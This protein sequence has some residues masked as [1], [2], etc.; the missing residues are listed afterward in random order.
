M[1]LIAVPELGARIFRICRE[2]CFFPGTTRLPSS[3]RTPKYIDCS[4]QGL[5]RKVIGLDLLECLVM[6]DSAGD[7]DVLQL[8]C[9]GAIPDGL[10]VPLGVAIE[11]E[12]AKFKLRPSDPSILLPDVLQR[13]IR[14]GEF[15]MVTTEEFGDGRKPDV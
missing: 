1:A 15:G 12:F 10:P 8:T 4:L 7:I 11:G 5:G 2:S 3:G 13:S 9:L 6:L 14:L